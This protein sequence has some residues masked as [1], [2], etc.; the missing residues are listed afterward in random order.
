MPKAL[1]P[2]YAVPVGIPVYGL[3]F[4]SDNQLIV[5][6]GGGAGRSGVANKLVDEVASWL[7]RRRL[8]ITATF[9]SG[10]L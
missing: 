9:C 6:G 4:T 5:A 10:L 8:I 7:E 2:S 1:C 3:A